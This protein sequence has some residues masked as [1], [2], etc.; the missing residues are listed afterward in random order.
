MI[1]AGSRTDRSRAEGTAPAPGS[2]S[3]SSTGAAVVAVAALAA[4]AF[5]G[6]WLMDVVAAAAKCATLPLPRAAHVTVDAASADA[7]SSAAHTESAGG[8][9]WTAAA[10]VGTVSAS[11]AA[12]WRGGTR[13]GGPLPPAPAKLETT[14]TEITG[15]WC[16]K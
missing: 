5:P 16:G 8:L 11:L 15:M 3:S 2:A 10:L 12:G 1:D 4:A 9:A 7:A 13:K 14:E 6:T